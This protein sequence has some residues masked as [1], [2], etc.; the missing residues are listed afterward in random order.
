MTKKGDD[1]LLTKAKKVVNTLV[2]LSDRSKAV[3]QAMSVSDRDKCFEDAYVSL[4]NA[5]YP[6]QEDSMLDSRRIG[7]LM[8]VTVYDLSTN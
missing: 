6:D 4:F 7:D 8:Y 5:V 1:N 3:I 2:S